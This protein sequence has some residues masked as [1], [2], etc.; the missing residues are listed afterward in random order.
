[1]NLKNVRC[2]GRMVFVAGLAVSTVAGGASG[3]TLNWNNSL[4]G[5]A[6]TA[7][8]WNPAQVPTAANPLF[9]GLSAAYGVTFSGTVGAS[10]SMTIRRGTPTFSMTSTHST[11]N[12]VI[13]DLAGAPPTLVLTT[14]TLNCD[15]LSIGT[16]FNANGNVDVNDDDA[17]LLASGQLTVAD[18]T[19]LV[20]TLDITGGGRVEAGSITLGNLNGAGEGNVTVSGA[21]LSPPFPRSTLRTTSAT[22]DLIVGRN[23]VGMLTIAAG[24][25]V[26]ASRDMFIGKD[27]IAP[28]QN[29]AG[30]VTVGGLGLTGSTLN[31]A[32][33]LYIGRDTLVSQDAGI[34][35]LE[36]STPGVVNVLSL[37]AV[38]GSGTGSGTLRVNT[39]GRLNTV[40]LVFGATGEFQ[41]NGGTVAVSGGAF[42]HDEATL[43]VSGAGAGPVLVL[44]ALANAP[45]F[46]AGTTTSDAITIGNAGAGTLTM[47]NGTEVSVTQGSIRL[48]NGAASSGTLNVE[49]GAVLTASNLGQVF[50]GDEGGGVFNVRSGA[51]T[52]THSIVVSNG[53]GAGTFLAENMG[54]HATADSLSVRNGGTAVIRDGAMVTTNGLFTTQVVIENGATLSLNDATLDATSIVRINTGGSFTMTSGVVRADEFICDV[55]FS[56]SGLIDAKVQVNPLITATG[57]LTLG[58]GSNVAIVTP[59]VNV[60]AHR[61]NYHD[62]SVAFLGN[63]T[64]NGGIIAA[65]DEFILPAN[66]AISGTGLVIGELLNLGTITATG[67]NG[68]TFQDMLTGIGQG[69]GGTRFVFQNGGGYTGNGTINSK[70]VGEQGSRIVISGAPAAIGD[71]STFGFATDGE[72]DISSVTTLNDSNGAGLG[73]LTTLRSTTLICASGIT[74]GTTPTLDTLNGSGIIQGNVTNV[75]VVVPGTPGIDSTQQFNIVGVYSHTSGTSRGRLEME[76]GGPL[77]GDSDRIIATSCVLAGT[78]NVSL[79][80]GFVPSPGLVVPMVA[81]SS[82][83]V[84]TFQTV[85]L[86]PG[87]RIR[88]IFSGAEVVYCPSD[89][90]G[91]GA[92]NSQDFFDFIAAF[93]ALSPTADFNGDNGVNSQDFFDFLTAF[94]AGGC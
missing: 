94:F 50:V 11:G 23:G 79:I 83:R 72:M 43:T 22:G 75:G 12:M 91:D 31:V 15:D 38:G 21:I 92:T 87:F 86:P 65:S 80:N 13:G 76:I 28:G 17:D 63:T 74:L 57:E 36:I 70:V 1:M 14:G 29:S 93:F 68:L 5:A 85:N 39:G 6:S 52:N 18:D 44:D 46:A 56:A 62:S 33:D 89:F 37:T 73:T 54:T 64:L 88:Y 7:A 82:A 77:P 67:T 30:T 49:S 40:S 78:L 24:A 59:D 26:E 19:N 10:S 84:G 20:C 27:S 35:L 34:G 8:N 3:Q 25:L 42:T 69:I 55:P 90:N 32:D 48:G 53:S 71:G 58:D 2:G 66:E 60:G 61:V 41:H 9:F 47:S 45:V 81:T 4:G 16:V 51:Q